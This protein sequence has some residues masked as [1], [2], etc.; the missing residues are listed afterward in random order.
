MRKIM[1]KAYKVGFGKEI[2][3]AWEYAEKG[4]VAFTQSALHF[5]R[6]YAEKAG[7]GFL[8]RVKLELQARYL[9]FKAKRNEKKKAF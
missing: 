6:K 8:G 5:A 2:A 3:N 7:I 1:K 4:N 9:L